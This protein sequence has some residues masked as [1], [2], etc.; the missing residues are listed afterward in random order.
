MMQGTIKRTYKEGW[1]FITA[2]T[3]G[4]VFFHRSVLHGEPFELIE[5]GMRVA[6]TLGEPKAGKGPRASAVYV[7]ASDAQ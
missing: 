7:G 3:G 2:D 6:Y 5:A 1:G 4:D